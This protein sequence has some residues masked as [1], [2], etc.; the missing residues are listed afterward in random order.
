MLSS[1]KLNDNV[2][3]SPF[4]ACPALSA[5]FGNAPFD[6]N[7]NNVALV[8]LEKRS[9]LFDTTY[10][11]PMVINVSAQGRYVTLQLVP[12]AGRTDRD[13]TLCEFEIFGTESSQN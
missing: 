11:N 10:D 7:Q 5:Y 6:P 3:I 8:T 13:L 1:M 4:L 12:E 9:F 2:N